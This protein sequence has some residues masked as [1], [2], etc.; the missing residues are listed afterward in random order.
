MNIY[1][2]SVGEP[3]HCVGRRDFLF[4]GALSLSTVALGA[5]GAP[6][7]AAPGVVLLKAEYPRLGVGTLSS[8]ADGA[9][10]Y[11]DYPRPGLGN[12][13]L[14]L[15]SPA[16]AGIGP[17]RDAVAFSLACTHMG[18]NLWGSL[19]PLQSTLGPCPGHLTSF[20]LSRHGMVITGHA[21]ESLPQIILELDGD[22]IHAVGVMGLV[23]GETAVSA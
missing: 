7:V 14:R 6:M 9:P 2:S 21:T 5:L 12:A 15:G 1:L 4:A 19:R 22:I 20:D 11:F 8:L 18:M 3:R 23:F 17:G 10:R 16:G 13:L